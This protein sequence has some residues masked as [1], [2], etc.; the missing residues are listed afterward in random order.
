MALLG[1]WPK[2]PGLRHW[3][4]RVAQSEARTVVIPCE[5]TFHPIRRLVCR[6]RRAFCHGISLPI[7][8]QTGLP[9]RQR[10]RGFCGVNLRVID[11]MGKNRAAAL[12]EG[13]KQNKESSLDNRGQCP[14]FSYGRTVDYHNDT[15]LNAVVYDNE[16]SKK[17][18]PLRSTPCSGS[19]E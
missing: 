9:C 16:F 8:R 2:L 19:A 11:A 14:L 10:E 13:G 4:N 12:L 3:K 6:F 15:D 5:Q 18:L 1:S 17:G 7:L